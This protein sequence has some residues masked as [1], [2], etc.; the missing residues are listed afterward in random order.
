M[1]SECTSDYD[2]STVTAEFLED[3]ET[4]AQL[5]R[6]HYDEMAKIL[7]AKAEDI[8][9][10]AQTNNRSIQHLDVSSVSEL[11]ALAYAV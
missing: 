1:P 8:K 4:Y 6:S 10:Y 5:T 7:K 3:M 11:G 2:N 9:A